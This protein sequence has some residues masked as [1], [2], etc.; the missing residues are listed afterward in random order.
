MQSQRM[1]LLPMKTESV[2]FGVPT[3]C[4]INITRKGWLNNMGK[5]NK[6]QQDR[7]VHKNYDNL[8]EDRPNQGSKK[9][10]QQRPPK[11]K[12]EKVEPVIPPMAQ[13]LCNYFAGQVN[14]YALFI[15]SENDDLDAKRDIERALLNITKYPS[16]VSIAINPDAA[17]EEVENEVVQLYMLD[18]NIK[19]DKT[20]HQ[21][22]RGALIA[23][24]LKDGVPVYYVNAYVT[25]DLI[26]NIMVAPITEKGTDFRN[27]ARWSNRPGQ[28]SQS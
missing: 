7:Y 14:D 18:R 23:V 22:V 10:F 11:E 25:K 20:T 8:L 15:R 6:K 27:A 2:T 21:L 24:A 1:S 19:F 13:F 9:T 3:P 17:P 5:N 12:R 16:E 4:E 28:E 26:G